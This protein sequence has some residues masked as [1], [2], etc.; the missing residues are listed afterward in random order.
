ML[1][2]L[3]R[4]NFNTESRTRIQEIL[5]RHLH[6][7]STEFTVLLSEALLAR[8]HFLV[9]SSPKEAP[10]WDERDIERDIAQAVRRWEDDLK[11]A[12]VEAVKSVAK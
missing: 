11:A 5:K 9:R 1:V 3:P 6:G 7:T 10:G 8:I 12:L 2:Y 4:E